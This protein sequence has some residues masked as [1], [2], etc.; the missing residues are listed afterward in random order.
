MCINNCDKYKVSQ[1]IYTFYR[2]FDNNRNT[3]HTLFSEYINIT[4]VN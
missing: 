4:L 2:I 1:F 3:V